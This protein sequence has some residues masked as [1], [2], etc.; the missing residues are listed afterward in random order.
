[1]DVTCC[2]AKTAS[3]LIF[4]ELG[5]INIRR[6]A[7]HDMLSSCQSFT[8]LLDQRLISMGRRLNQVHFFMPYHIKKVSRWLMHAESVPGRVHCICCRRWNYRLCCVCVCLCVCVCIGALYQN[9]LCTTLV[10]IWSKQRSTL[11]SLPSLRRSVLEF[12]TDSLKHQ[13]Q[14]PLWSATEWNS[15]SQVFTHMGS[16][17]AGITKLREYSVNFNFSTQIRFHH[18]ALC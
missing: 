5:V 14:T 9:L 12:V 15:R 8:Q 11:R 1:M 4:P 18:Q 16:S 2:K 6:S 3:C 13:Q 10:P 17:R 7:P